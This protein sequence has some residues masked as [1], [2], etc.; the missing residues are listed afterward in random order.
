MK[1][2]I[3]GGCG[4]IGSHLV[5][6]FQENGASVRVLDNLSI[7]SLKNLAGLDFEFFRG[8][9]TDREVVRKATM[10]IDVICHLAALSK[11]SESL[12]KP[13]DYERVNLDGLQNVLH[14]GIRA[15]A[16]KLIFSSSASVYGANPPTPTL[17]SVSAAP[18]HPYGRT[19]FLGERLL[20]EIPAQS[21]IQTTT[22]RLFNVFGP[23]Q[24]SHG[25]E[26]PVISR[27]SRNAVEKKPLIIHGDGS[28]TRDF[29]YVKDVV[30]AFCLA[31]ESEK[32]SGT[33][34]LGSGE[35]TSLK[36]V[37]EK[38]QQICKS[39]LAVKY[40]IERAGD[41]KHSL[42]DVS[43]LKKMGWQIGYSLEEA[44]GLTAAYYR[45]EASH[46]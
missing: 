42:A 1:I 27:F 37:A 17:E 23:R 11:V 36:V 5:E 8:S 4:F 3:T 38:I 24:P 21:S 22:F 32:L 6:G 26:A 30:R 16:S 45:T 35:A 15:G 18:H 28:Q 33:Y 19:K 34:N 39:D 29:V 13:L 14:E 12:R 20:N 44:L 43:G 25:T 10:G 7:G 9:I 2:L 31:V 46:R 40:R 41:A